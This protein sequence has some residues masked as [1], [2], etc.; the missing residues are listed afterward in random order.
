MESS[1]FK[2]M[3]LRTINAIQIKKTKNMTG[4]LKVK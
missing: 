3:M 2:K 1:R 4:D